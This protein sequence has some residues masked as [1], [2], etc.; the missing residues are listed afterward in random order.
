M[1]VRIRYGN[2]LVALTISILLSL[3]LLRKMPLAIRHHAP[4]MLHVFIIILAR[5]FLRVLL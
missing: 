1:H 5:I 2:S 3:L 4:H